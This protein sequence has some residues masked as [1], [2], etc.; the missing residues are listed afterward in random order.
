[1]EYL[2]FTLNFC[3]IMVLFELCWAAIGLILISFAS[4]F[5]S[6]K[7]TKIA[8]IIEKIM[9]CYFIISV[10]ILV[11]NKFHL[12]HP[13]VIFLIFMILIP[14]IYFVFFFADKRNNAE[15]MIRNPS[16]IFTREYESMTDKMIIIETIAIILFIPLV[17]F[18]NILSN[19]LTINAFN[20][21]YYVATIK[22]LGTL[23]GIYGLFSLMRY[24]FTIGLM[25]TFF[26]KQ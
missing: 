5:K 14:V 4:I 2:K 26:R 17:F 20:G 19:F 18:P 16:I 25:A 9:Y 22:V 24:F 21:L 8:M 23:L 12:N 7:V 15:K 6:N 3:A 13:Q 1:M 10:S 11:I